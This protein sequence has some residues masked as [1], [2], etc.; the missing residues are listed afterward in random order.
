MTKTILFEIIQALYKIGYIVV[1]V[2][3]DMGSTNMALWKSLN[4]GI[5]T[6]K[7]SIDVKTPTTMA[8]QNFF[9]HPA[10]ETLKCFVFADVPHLIKLMRNNLFDSGFNIDGLTVNKSILEELVDLN[11]SDLK[12]AF[13]LSRDHLDAKGFQRQNVKLAAQVFSLRN[14]R[15]IKYCGEQ[16]FFEDKNWKA[17]GDMIELVNNWFDLLNSQSKYGNHSG[18]RAYGVELEYQ[19]NVLDRMNE[20]ISKMKVCG[21]KSLMPF[22]KGILLVNKSLKELFLH[23]K[24]KYTF[25]NFIP[26]YIITRR[27]S[28]DI[29]E[30]FFAHIRSMGG[31]HGNPSPVQ[32][33]IRLK[34]YILEKHSEY[35]ISVKTNAETDMSSTPFMDLE[36]VCDSFQS[37]L[38]NSFEQDEVAMEEISMFNEGLQTGIEENSNDMHEV[39]EEQKE[40]TGNPVHLIKRKRTC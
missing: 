18:L 21:K 24:E 17:M 30:N 40:N 16:G 2:T 8:K 35:G 38:M 31:L 11:K 6:S 27:L 29:L 26:E 23:L 34:W 14:A 4:I 33:Q 28:Q 5:E 39:E 9:L 22:Q 12:I 25:E 1:C 3:S 10:D 13:N 15:A 20:F 19:D 7:N 36:D 32:C 37:E